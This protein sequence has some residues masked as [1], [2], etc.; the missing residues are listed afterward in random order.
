[1]IRGV[2]G[3]PIGNT[4]SCQ[5]HV[6]LPE[7]V[8]IGKAYSPYVCDAARSGWESITVIFEKSDLFDEKGH[9][10]FGWDLLL[11]GVSGAVS[12]GYA[13]TRTGHGKRRSD[14]SMIT[15]RPSAPTGS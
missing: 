13:T 15:T 10:L 4:S 3:I 14:P 12:A 1:M 5:P 2:P 6:E 11:I 9:Q 8:L 7:H